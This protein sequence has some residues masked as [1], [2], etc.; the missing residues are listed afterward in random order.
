YSHGYLPRIDY[1]ETGR[2]SVRA[3]TEDEFVESL[4]WSVHTLDDEQQSK[5]RQYYREVIIG[6]NRP[7]RPVNWAFIGWETSL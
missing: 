2:G 6:Q 7:P 4:I 1:I 3:N 5:A